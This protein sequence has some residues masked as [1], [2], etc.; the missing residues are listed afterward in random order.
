MH[1]IP[2]LDNKGLRQFGLLMAGVIAALFGLL[3]PW[4]F[5]AA[6]P[7]WPWILA[8]AFVVMALLFPQALTP[9]YRGWMHFGFFMSRITTPL[10]L[11]LV[12]FLAILPTG[13]IM[14]A[15]GRDPMARDRNPDAASYRVP[16]EKPDK[17]N[18][19]KPF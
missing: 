11:G 6:W 9:V 17:A 3:L 5:D 1:E 2:E 13:L 8:G 4:L 18:L 19:E 14:R 15:F 12:F 16:S 7:R 10:L